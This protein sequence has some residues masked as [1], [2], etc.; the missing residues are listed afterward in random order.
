M[1]EVGE[2]QAEAAVGEQLQEE[3]QVLQQESPSACPSCYW[4]SW[5]FYPTRATQIVR[6]VF[7]D[8]LT[9]LRTRN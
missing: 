2:V 5:A 6:L 8:A 4:Y 1:R 7:S 9:R 3:V